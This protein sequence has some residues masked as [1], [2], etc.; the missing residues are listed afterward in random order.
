MATARSSGVAV[1]GTLFT[2]QV[3][4]I[5]KPITPNSN[6]QLDNSL[7]TSIAILENLPLDLDASI[8]KL[9]RRADYLQHNTLIKI[10]L[11]LGYPVDP[12]GV[13]HAFNK[14]SRNAIQVGEFDV[15]EKRVQFINQ[16]TPDSIFQAL[17]KIKRKL[18]K[19]KKLDETD[20]A[21]LDIL[22]FFE[23]IVII[24]EP[25]K[26]SY[27]FPANANLNQGCKESRQLVE[28]LALADKNGEDVILTI[29]AILNENE[30]GQFLKL[31]ATICDE[32]KVTEPI[33][34]SFKVVDHQIDITFLPDKSEW[35]FVDSNHL[36]KTKF[37][38]KKLF[39]EVNNIASHLYNLYA[40]LV[41]D[42]QRSPYLAMTV[43][44][45]TTNDNSKA[46]IFKNKIIN[47]KFYNDVS[48]YPERVG[49]MKETFLHHALLTDYPRELI[50]FSNYKP[51]IN[52]QNING[53]TPLLLACDQRADCVEALLEN[54]ANPNLA[55]KNGFSPLFIALSFNDFRL[56]DLLL[57]YNVQKYDHE[58]ILRCACKNV[59]K[60]TLKFLFSYHKKIDL[61]NKPLA[62]EM[63]DPNTSDATHIKWMTSLEYALTSNK[64]DLA[65][66]LIELKADISPALSKAILEQNS[67]VFTFL[68]SKLSADKRIG[69][70]TKKYDEY[71]ADRD[72]DACLFLAQNIGTPH[73]V[74]DSLLWKAYQAPSVTLVLNLIEN[75]LFTANDYTRLLDERKNVLDD[76]DDL[77]EIIDAMLKKAELEFA[78][79]NANNEIAKILIKASALANEKNTVRPRSPLCLFDTSLVTKKRGSKR[80]NEDDKFKHVTKRHC[81]I[82]E[83]N[84]TF[85]RP[86]K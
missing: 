22:I 51:Y 71:L 77:D 17:K 65:N 73:S 83:K 20:L 38:S 32:V 35:I 29:P 36:D 74:S 75:K 86:K 19:E 82:D 18:K 30:I 63:S 49:I 12:D 47:S 46:L 85:R 2:P 39:K 16:N 28:S 37:T 14:A 48:H 11:A 7:N 59:D 68:T 53:V 27:L 21:Y 9:E 56:V 64:V 55:D 44:A 67:H 4:P 34:L 45:C 40:K 42:N 33:T 52:A 79:K 43:K 1:K 10:M 60:S 62:W 54:N 81:H 3:S 76:V 50:N 57:K 58:K 6:S 25:K 31:Y 84:I 15:F 72:L 24:Q 66:F 5:A 8:E 69:F 41:P 26:V 61:L 13:C 23:N 78:K 80:S 70:L